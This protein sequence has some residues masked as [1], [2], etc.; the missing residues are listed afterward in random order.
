L[1][2]PPGTPELRPT[3]AGDLPRLRDVFLA[4][5]G[6]LF[7]RLGLP[8]PAPSEAAFAAVQGHIAETGISA[9]AERD[10]RIEG[11]AS[12]LVRG[13]DWF[14]SS[15]YVLPGAQGAGLGSRLLETVWS[16][17]ARR[18]T[19]TDAFQPVSN[20]LYGR[21]GLIPATPL[22]SFDGVPARTDAEAEEAPAD[23]AAI[24]AAAYGFDRALDHRYWSRIARRSEWGDAY[25]YV[26]Q[27]G[28]IGPVAGLDAAAA[29]RALAAELARAEGTVRVRVLGSARQ[30]VRVA[31]GAGLRL[32]PVAGFLLCSDGVEPP[33]AL[34]PSGYALF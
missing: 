20:A 19:I 5:T 23:L 11:F 24:D 32:S 26:F 10:G 29:A 22:L 2:T 17:V 3:R 9:V 1:S 21:R 13:E 8:A 15:L 16:D 34:A 4:A 14:L 7:G 25:S 30:L 18:R 27:G 33:T 28:E 12:A 6:E 31:L